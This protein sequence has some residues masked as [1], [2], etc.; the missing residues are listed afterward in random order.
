MSFLNVGTIIDERYRI[1]D[2]P[3]TTGGMQYVYPA[4]DLVFERKVA[5]KTPKNPEGEKRFERSARL[6]AL[7]NHVNVTRTLD[8]VVEGDT[9]YLIEEFVDGLDLG[10]LLKRIK[11]FDPYLTATILHAL[12]RA[13]HVMHAQDVVHRDLKP[14]NIMAVGGW[15]LTGIKVTDFGVANLAEAAVDRGVAGGVLTIT[16]SKTLIG[17]LPYL[18][19]EI[20]R[21]RTTISKSADIWAVGALIYHFIAGQTPFGD[22]LEAVTDIV[23]GNIRPLPE[24]IDDQ[25]QYRALYEE[26]NGI[27]RA[28]MQ[29]DPEKR[30]KAS[31][32]LELCEKLC[33]PV[34]KREIGTVTRHQ[35]MNFA[36]ATSPEGD[37][38]FHIDSVLG[39]GRPRIGGEIW[40]SRHEGSPNDRAH[41]VVPLLSED[42]EE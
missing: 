26:M 7:L 27:A 14:S 25:P 39:S 13:L 35:G 15:N 6:S 33:Y 42:D 1:D 11:R 34:A 19:P 22:E 32:L 29:L 4:T 17:A 30:P 16:G 10:R 23:K 28:C 36:F 5:L 37:V 12:A 38:F 21:K 24:E 20:L 9:Q 18:A 2:K 40:F 41:P 31:Q 8:Y 3:I